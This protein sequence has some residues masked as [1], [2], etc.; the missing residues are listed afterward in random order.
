MLALAM[1][2]IM[3]VE[4]QQERQEI[5]FA[6]INLVLSQGLPL[7]KI[8]LSTDCFKIKSYKINNESFFCSK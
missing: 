3:K 2:F 7:I 1:D 6:K 8:L 4:I 5:S